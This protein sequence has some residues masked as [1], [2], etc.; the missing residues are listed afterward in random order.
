MLVSRKEISIECV[1]NA[2]GFP[3]VVIYDDKT[4]PI[5]SQQDVIEWHASGSYSSVRPFQIAHDDNED[6]ATLD[7]DPPETDS[8]LPPSLQEEEEVKRMT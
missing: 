4:F 8:N 1:E 3:G 5:P 2:D 6:P 7:W